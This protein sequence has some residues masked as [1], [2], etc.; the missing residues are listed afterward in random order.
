[1]ETEKL[2]RG[3]QHEVSSLYYKDTWEKVAYKSSKPMIFGV[4]VT[5]MAWF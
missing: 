1:M 4:E 2:S 3:H 5:K